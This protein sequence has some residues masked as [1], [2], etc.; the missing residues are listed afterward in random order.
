VPG[1]QP[2]I[3]S[4]TLSVTAPKPSGIGGLSASGNAAPAAIGARSLFDP[5]QS[6]Y[7]DAHVYR[8]ADIGLGATIPGPAAL[9]EDQTTT[10]VPSGFSA[11][12]NEL[13]HLVLTRAF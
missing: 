10:I 7:V 2:E 13:G 9:T 6:D 11:S 8:R 1:Q 5:V 3:L 12:V 4:W